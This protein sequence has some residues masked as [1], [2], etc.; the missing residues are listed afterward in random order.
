MATDLRISDTLVFNRSFGDLLKGSIKLINELDTSKEYKLVISVGDYTNKEIKKMKSCKA[1]SLKE[2]GAALISDLKIV[3]KNGID[4]VFGSE[5][6]SVSTKDKD[7]Y[8]IFGTREYDIFHIFNICGVL[9]SGFY[10][11]ADEYNRITAQHRAELEKGLKATAEKMEEIPDGE[12]KTAAKK[13]ANNKTRAA[14]KTATKKIVAD[15][16]A[17]A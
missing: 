11:S 13:T 1:L 5:I 7:D 17:T 16:G 2:M 14:K 15:K 10:I 12:K 8:V 3:S 6:Y 4:S 9:V